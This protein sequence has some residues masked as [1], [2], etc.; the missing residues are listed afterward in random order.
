MFL[1][2]LPVNFAE[3]LR[4]VFITEL[5]VPELLTCKIE[6]ALAAIWKWN[7]I[8]AMIISAF[9]QDSVYFPAKDILSK[10]S[11]Y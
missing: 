7:Y 3:L 8:I 1:F 9:P 11:R 6:N 2:F 5:F 4:I 10:K